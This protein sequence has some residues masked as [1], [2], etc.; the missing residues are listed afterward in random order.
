MRGR[1]VV[2]V[3]DELDEVRTP[4]TIVTVP[5]FLAVELPPG[6]WYTTTPIVT[7]LGDGPGRLV[8]LEP[9]RAERALRARRRVADHAGDRDG[10]RGRGHGDRDVGAVAALVL[11]AGLWLM[12]LPT[13]TVDEAWFL[14][15]AREAGAGEVGGG[16][17]LALAHDRRHL[18]LRRAR[19]DEQG[20]REPP[21]H[22]VAHSG[23]GR[24]RLAGRE[25]VVGALDRRFR[26]S[27]RRGAAPS[28]PRP[29]SDPA[30]SGPRRRR[31]RWRRSASPSSP[32]R[33]WCRPPGTR[34]TT[35]PDGLRFGT[36]TVATWNLACS[37]VACAMVTCSPV[38]LGTRTCLGRVRK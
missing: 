3:E 29:R 37:T 31:G 12:T 17:R 19:G 2:V 10:G 18:L 27:D 22:I 4:T 15:C 34:D 16:L 38:T 5:P 32:C 35:M 9:R 21:R 6:V 8:H 23:I 14:V 25:I 28:W 7:G 13:G 36:D 24:R 26:P 11:P 1:E 33:P 20:D 30:P